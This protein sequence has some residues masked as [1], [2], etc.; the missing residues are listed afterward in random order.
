METKEQAAALLAEGLSI[1]EIA[2]RTQARVLARMPD[3]ADVTVLSCADEWRRVRY[4]ALEGYCMAAYLRAAEEA[5]VPLPR[6][7]ATQLRDALARALT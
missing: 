2:Q 3:G 5:T 4:Q 1:A 7:L 6:A